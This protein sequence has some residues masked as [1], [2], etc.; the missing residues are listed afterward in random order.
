MNE[1]A[2]NR[3]TWSDTLLAKVDLSLGCKVVGQYLAN[4]VN[5][6]TDRC[7]PSQATIA[8]GTGLTIRGVQKAI[9]K[10]KAAGLIQI[11]GKHG[12]DLRYATQV[13]KLIPG[14]NPHSG[15][16]D[17]PP[18][19]SEPKPDTN[20]GSPLRHEPRFTPE[21]G[22]GTNTVTVQGRTPV[23]DIEPLREPPIKNTPTEY[24]AKPRQPPLK[25][26]KRKAS[27]P[28]PPNPLWDALQA[29]FY[30]SGIAPG[31]EK[32]VGALVRD[33]KAKGATPDEIRKRADRYKKAW[34]D[35]ACTP[36][37][38]LEHWDEF[39]PKTRNP[40]MPEPVKGVDEL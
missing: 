5:K 26:E 14:T 8:S 21:S 30:P 31:Q 10:L 37:A 3:F 13:Y 1:S 27:K 25:K 4:R 40:L 23:R 22:S 6:K 12:D 2:V 36:N 34:P 20:P 32:H 7:F 19:T 11:V 18:F 17:E 24:A 16:R 15:L 39:A 38:L 29:V 9:D 33:F 28:R 35:Y